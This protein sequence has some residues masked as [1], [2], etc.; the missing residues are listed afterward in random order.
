MAGLPHMAV[1]HKPSVYGRG[2]SYGSRARA[3]PNMA[4]L[5]LMAVEHEPSLIWQPPLLRQSSTSPP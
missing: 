4:G 5:P 3:L 1:E 2:P